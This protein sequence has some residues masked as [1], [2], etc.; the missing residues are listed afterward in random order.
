[1]YCVFLGDVISAIGRQSWAEYKAVKT[2]ESHWFAV[3]FSL[4]FMASK[5]G[6][7]QSMEMMYFFTLLF[8]SFKRGSL[9]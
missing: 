2:G 6:V 5:N 9:S 4:C 8:L 3:V 1:M 7:I